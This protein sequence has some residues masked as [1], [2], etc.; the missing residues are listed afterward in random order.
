VSRRALTAL[1]LAVVVGFAGA[2][3]AKPKKEK[4]EK[5]EKR[6]TETS[7]SSG[8]GSPCKRTRPVMQPV[9]SGMPPGPDRPSE[10]ETVACDGC[11]SAADCTAKPQGG[12]TLAGNGEAC[13]PA[14]AFVCRYPNDE[15]TK[16]CPYCTND[17]KGH[18]I[19]Q[20]VPRQMPPS[21][22][23]PRR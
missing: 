21:A 10:V 15:C 16:D 3:V 8:K 18:A 4:A 1:A 23:P 11:T 6:A 7:A 20:R 12:C 14:A 22:A 9:C 19:C 13:E 2:G 17:G 5:A